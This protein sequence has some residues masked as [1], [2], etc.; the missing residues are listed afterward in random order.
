[1]DR[2]VKD[3]ER[4]RARVQHAC[5]ASGP[6]IRA[7]RNAERALKRLRLQVSLL[8]VFGDT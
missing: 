6:T 3:V 1:M 2:L 8:A 5:A 4:I 7:A